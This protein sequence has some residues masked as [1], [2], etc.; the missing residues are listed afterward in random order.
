MEQRLRTDAVAR[1]RAA[2]ILDRD[3]S[4]L[5]ITLEARDVYANPTLV[6]DPVGEAVPLAH[7]PRAAQ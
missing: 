7:G 1:R 2:K 3:G 6:T 5:A 4:P